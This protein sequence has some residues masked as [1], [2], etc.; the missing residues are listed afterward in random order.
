MY[1]LYVYL[2][3]NNASITHVTFTTVT[4]QEGSNVTW[5]KKYY[6]MFS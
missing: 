1:S 6:L 3:I 4:L 5:G 2:Q